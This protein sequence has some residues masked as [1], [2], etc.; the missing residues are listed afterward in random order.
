LSDKFPIQNGLKQG[1]ALSP[2]CF[3]LALE[4]TIREVQES[5]VG[6]KL[7]GTHKLLVYADDVNLLGD[8]INT[9]KENSEILLE[10]S[11]D[12]CLAVTA[13][14][15]KYVIMFH[16]PNLVQNKNIRIAN[17]SFENVAK[18]KYLGMTLTN[19]ND[20]HDEIKSRLNLECLL[21]FSPKSYVFPSHNKKPKDQNIQNYNFASCTVWVQNL[22]SHFEGET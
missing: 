5:Q 3:N 9:I 20:I 4:Y 12:V 10:A 2:L 8:I 19:K 17:E 7:N 13:E 6:L 15:T 14:K 18:F 21:S 16:H 11:R 22:V 1:N